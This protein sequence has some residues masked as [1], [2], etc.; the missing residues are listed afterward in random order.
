M[1]TP[2]FRHVGPPDFHDGRVLQVS[3]PA[4]DQVHVRVQGS[5]GRLYLVRFDQVHAVRAVRPENML[6]YALTE[7]RDSDGTVRFVFSNWDDENE[8][9]LEIFAPTVQ[10]DEEG[11]AA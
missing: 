8:A 9:A 3:Q 11:V 6:L 5:E 7:F 10:I 1:T 2:D 4:P